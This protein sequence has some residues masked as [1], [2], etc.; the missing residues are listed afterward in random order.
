MAEDHK[1]SSRNYGGQ[2]R[3]NQPSR[4]RRDDRNGKPYRGGAGRS[5][6]Y[7]D[8]NAGDNR[9]ARD[10]RGG[11]QGRRNDR[12]DRGGYQGRRNDRN[13]R[14]GYQGRRNDRN[15]RDDRGGDRRDGRR[16][17]ERKGG[18]KG[19]SGSGY[20][21]K[22]FDR[23]G[24]RGRD[25]EE[26]AR[27]E[28]QRVAGPEL[29]EWA[30][31]SSLPG[32]VR[33]ELHMLSKEN[34]EQVARH[35]VAAYGFID[36][37]PKRALAHANAARDHAGR[38]AVVRENAGVIAYLTGNWK[39]A[40]SELRAARRIGGGPGL[41]PMMADCQRA[42]DRPEKA[43]E[44]LESEP[45]HELDEDD[46]IEFIIVIAGAYSD[47]NEFDKAKKLLEKGNLDPEQT[48]SAAARLFYAYAETMLAMGDESAATTWFER[49][50]DA[51][52]EEETDAVER[53][54]E[55]KNK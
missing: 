52:T 20:K 54:A 40:L 22:R 49:S 25:R 7:R 35:M 23:R 55:L 15:E 14:G 45:V 32:D 51:D 34:A 24:G 53:F 13:D 2:R 6:T 29:P 47:L 50:A 8:R 16:Y 26:T 5:G 3:H 36:E 4:G 18:Y 43:I 44:M 31:A 12:D 1:S 21:G 10:N 27:T 38:I 11:Y 17:G 28:R 9:E 46:L 33:R 39:D 42:L 19:G 41:L 37:D 30:D 48:G